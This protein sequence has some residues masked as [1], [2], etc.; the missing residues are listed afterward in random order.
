MKQFIKGVLDIFI[1]VLLKRKRHIKNKQ[2]RVTT[3]SMKTVHNRKEAF[4]W[5]KKHD[6]HAPKL[7]DFA[8]DFEL[9]DS[10]GQHSI[11]LSDF[12]GKKPVVLVFGSFT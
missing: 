12:R 3:M 5:Q 1:V 6:L 8:P 2:K 7:G 4:S 10:K 11:R 9:K